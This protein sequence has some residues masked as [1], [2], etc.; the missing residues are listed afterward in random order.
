MAFVPKAGSIRYV[1]PFP[2]FADSQMNKILSSALVVEAIEDEEPRGSRVAGIFPDDVEV[3]IADYANL[4]LIAKS[5][6]LLILVEASETL[7]A[8]QGRKSY[9]F[10]RRRGC[11]PS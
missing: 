9:W 8:S 10:T 5:I 2:I 1:G 3:V 4:I 7:G 6:R 11:Y